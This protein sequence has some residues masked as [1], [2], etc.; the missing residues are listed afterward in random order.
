MAIYPS[1]TKTQS[2]FA[3]SS[4]DN[5]PVNRLSRETVRGTAKAASASGVNRQ[6][7]RRALRGVASLG[8]HL[9][10]RRRICLKN[11]V[12]RGTSAR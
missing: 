2:V 10:S 12:A 8:W 4:Q 6:G 7:N 3:E 1:A 5:P 11:A 9:R